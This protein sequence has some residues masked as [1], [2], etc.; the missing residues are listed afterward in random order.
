MKIAFATL[1][2]KV[3][4]YETSLMCEDLRKGHEVIPF[5]KKADIYIINTCSVTQKADYQ[6]RQL[7]RRAIKTNKDARV[8]VT[9]CYAERAPDEIRALGAHTVLGNSLKDQISEILGN[10]LADKRPY[11]KNPNPK[12]L[13]RATFNTGRTRSFLKIQD[14]CDYRCSYCIVPIVRGRSRSAPPSNIYEEV[15]LLVEKGYREIVLSGIQLGSYGKDLEPK[16]DLVGLLNNL[17]KINGLFRIRLSSIEPNDI[18]P[19]LISLIKSN[20]RV[21]RH[22]HIPLQSGDDEILSAMGRNYTS[23]YYRELIMTL[24]SEIPDICIGTDIIVG[25]PIETGLHFLRTYNFLSNLPISYFHVFSFSE[26]PGTLISG[27]KGL[28][29]PEEKK[30]RNRLVRLLGN[31][32]NISFKNNM[33]GKEFDILVENK[34]KSDEYLIGLTDNYLS[35]HLKVSKNMVNKIIRSR[36]KGF[37]G[38]FLEGEVIN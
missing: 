21:C 1:G 8:I 37:N 32:K 25:F 12:F 26:R 14:G 19:E 38:N 9:G 27:T 34:T 17:L 11:Y 15:K 29:S 3:N 30:R 16:T 13:C 18:T 2:C 31:D 5:D 28:I 6:S 10:L 23:S 22:L 4:Q 24:V 20:P 35:L 33:I 36:V 7:I